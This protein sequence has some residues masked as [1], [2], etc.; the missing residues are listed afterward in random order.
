MT[1]TQRD[2]RFGPR[3]VSMNRDEHGVIYVR[4]VHPLGSYPEK[5]TEKLDH[6]AQKSPDRVFMAQRDGSGNWR[7]LTYA[8]FR[9]AAR[10]VAQS[11]LHRNLSAERPIAILSGNDLEHAVLGFA[12]Y[13]A[14]IPYAPISTAYSLV[15]SDFGKL[16]YIFDLLTPGL[17]FINDAAPFRKA[18]EAVQPSDAEIVTSFS[19]LSSTAA[20]AEVDRAHDL[21]TPD[22]VA[23]ILFTS[24]STGTPKGVE[25]TQRMLTSNQEIVRSV[26]A[27]VDDE[28]PV[29]CDW[30]PWNHTFGGN[31]DVGF[32]LYN[33]GSFYIDEGRP[34]P[35]GMAASVRNLHDVCPNVYLNVP[36]GFEALIPFLRERRGFRERF[37]S[38]LKM[39]YYA[40][41]GLLQPVWDELDQLAIETCGERIMMFTGLGST[42]T[43]PA[44]LFP[45][46]DLRRAGEVGLPAP[47]VEL[48]LV[49]V[50][51]K[52]EARLRSPSVTTGYWRQP[53]L[54]RLA[55]DDEG[56]YRIGDAL[57][58][59]DPQDI[60]RGFI[61][62]GR[63]VEDFKLS[64]GTFVSAGPMR[65]RFLSHCAP[66]AH[67]AVIAGHDRDFVTAL[68]F[69][70]LDACRELAE[71]PVT[72]SAAETVAHPAVHAKFQAL[73]N[74]LAA[75]ATGS[76]NR[77]ARAILMPE[78]PAIDAHE[79]TDKG[80]INQGA[81][82]KN[83]AA[84]VV[85]LYSPRPSARVISIQK[86]A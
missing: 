64:T 42:E 2:V 70:A 60:M 73:L 41:A 19:T 28:P 51:D 8:E 63:M 18:L 58:F 61:F 7:T 50:G 17:I 48:K 26:L 32:V 15:S 11:L 77:I 43:G 45:G 81:V 44:A 13:Y 57:R 47:G 33:G 53:D 86:G 35:A 49:P 27:W 46:K 30:L 66:Y 68:V 69:P 34:T 55:F 65:G 72:A 74:E 78:P 9:S 6:W 59:V 40:G 3:D 23:K 25:N 80:S 20:T 62:D 21:V 38:R 22:T 52:L 29:I 67:D 76:S 14:G 54:T 10:N 12:A 4:P 37:F 1:T 83:R 16:R 36:K 5:L 84:L 39:F 75:D 24:G 31:H 79:V 71:L 85:D 82:L 56:F